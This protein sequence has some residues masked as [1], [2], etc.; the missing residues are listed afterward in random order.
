MSNPNETQP[1][2]SANSLDKPSQSDS[3]SRVLHILP[4]SEEV[5]S[6]YSNHGTFHEGDS[7]LDLFVVEDAVVKA[8][9]TAFLNLGIQAAAYDEKNCNISWL[10]MPRSSISKTPLRLSN[11]GRELVERVAFAFLRCSS[12]SHMD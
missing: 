8:G 5:K 6:L 12:N 11:S 2:A 3:N 4:R 10:A 1:C 7:G 9:E